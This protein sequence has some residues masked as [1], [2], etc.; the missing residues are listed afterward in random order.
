MKKVGVIAEP[1]PLETRSALVPE[2]AEN[3]HKA[4]FSLL[5]ESNA[6]AKSGFLDKD[7]EKAQAKIA[8][9]QEVIE[10]AD[11]LLAVDPSSL[12]KTETKPEGRIIVGLFD[13]FNQ[14][15][16]I[17]TLKNLGNTLI[18]L[19]LIPRSSRA[20]SMDALSSQANLAGYVAMIMAQMH[21][22]KVCPMFMTAA[23]TIKPARV[24][25]LGAGVAGLSAIATAKRLGAVVY[26]YDIRTQVRE[27]I[28]SLGGKFVEIKVSES[29]EGEGGYAKAL[30]AEAQAMQRTLLTQFAKDMDIIITTAQIPGRAAPLLLDADIVDLVRPGSVIIDLASSSGGNVK[31]SLPNVWQNIG[32]AKVYGADH[33]ARMVPKDAS[34]TYSKN[35]ANLVQILFT[36]SFEI[37][38][39]D[40][41]INSAVMCHQGDWHNER[42]KAFM[43]NE[44]G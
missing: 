12:A 22:S 11:I 37:N 30:S 31:G 13:P 25:V 1:N 38:F 10:D 20:Q 18:S 42:I 43:E 5:I 33:L 27:E 36:D 41:I 28:E 35:L 3:L 17:E 19:E 2:V 14:R 6:C 24:L 32:N 7:F 21:L 16:A 15:K 40:D 23:G 34:F 29:G 44:Q 4:G 9:R 26:G 39:S 8:L